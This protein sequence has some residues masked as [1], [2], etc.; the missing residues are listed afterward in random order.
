MAT[1]HR[2][3]D[4]VELRGR[5]PLAVKIERHRIAIFHHDGQFPACSAP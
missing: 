5:S 4:E 1:W 2:V 3:G